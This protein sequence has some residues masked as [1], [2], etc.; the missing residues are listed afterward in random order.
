MSSLSP[1]RLVNSQPQA[2]PVTSDS[3]GDICSFCLGDLSGIRSLPV[4]S[5][6]TSST[7][8]LP[9]PCLLAL[10]SQHQLC[11]ASRVSCLF[12]FTLSS[13]P[14]SPPSPQL[15]KNIPHP[16][17]KAGGIF[18][19]PPHRLGLNT[20]SSCPRP[21]G[22]RHNCFPTSSTQIWVRRAACFFLV[23]SFSAKL[24]L[25][26]CCSHRTQHSLLRLSDLLRGVPCIFC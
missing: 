12:L 3:E 26:S 21:P 19:P 10:W 9:L 4:L 5:W 15:H 16:S 23:N 18:L 1:A 6:P 13:R 24:G 17:R 25:V 8:A 14:G 11:L 7:P 2:L 20:L 22:F